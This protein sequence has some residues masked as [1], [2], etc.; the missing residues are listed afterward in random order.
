M[1][2]SNSSSNH[3]H[4][5]F[6][7]V[8]GNHHSTSTYQLPSTTSNTTSN[9]IKSMS[10][11]A[12]LG[13][14]NL[15]EKSS[16]SSKDF[17]NHHHSSGHGASVQVSSNWAHTLA[18]PLPDPTQRHHHRSNHKQLPPSHPT[19]T[20][21]TT[22]SSSTATRSTSSSISSSNESTSQ[23]QSNTQPN[24]HTHTH[25]TSTSLSSKSLTRNSERQQTIY[26]PAGFDPFNPK[27]SQ[28]LTSL[29]T[30][31]NQ[32][33]T[34]QAANPTGLCDSP[35]SIE[36][37]PTVQ[38]T[39]TALLDILQDGSQHPHE[40]SIFQR[41]PSLSNTSSKSGPTSSSRN[42]SA[43]LR[44]QSNSTPIIGLNLGLDP[45]NSFVSHPPRAST[46]T[47]SSSSVGSSPLLNNHISPFSHLT[48]HSHLFNH[49]TLI[50]N[51]NL[52][53]HERN[54]TN[55]SNRASGLPF[56]HSD[57]SNSRFTRRASSVNTPSFS[58]VQDDLDDDLPRSRRPSAPNLTSPLP[59]DLTF[60]LNP[61][62]THSR[63]FTE[64]GASLETY[65]FGTAQL[66][67]DL[68]SG[69]RTL[70]NDSY[71]RSQGLTRPTRFDYDDQRYESAPPLP[72]CRTRRQSTL[73]NDSL[74]EINDLF[75]PFD[76]SAIISH[77]NLY[78]P[79][80]QSGSTGSDREKDAPH[81]VRALSTD[82]SLYA[83]SVSSL[84][85]YS[86][87]HHRCRTGS[88]SSGSTRCPLLD[89]NCPDSRR[90]SDAGSIMPMRPLPTMMQADHS[91]PSQ[92]HN[93]YNYYNPKP[94]GF[95]HPAPLGLIR[96]SPTSMIPSSSILSSNP[97]S[98][99][100]SSSN[101]I[102]LPSTGPNVFLPLRRRF[103]PNQ[104]DQRTSNTKPRVETQLLGELLLA[105]E[106]YVGAFGRTVKVSGSHR[107]GAS[108]SSS[109]AATVVVAVTAATGGSSESNGTNLL[110]SVVDLHRL[111]SPLIELEEESFIPNRCSIDS[112]SS[113]SSSEESEIPMRSKSELK[114][115]RNQ[116]SEV[117]EELE[118][119]TSEVVD[120]VPAFGEK[121]MQGHYGPL[122]VRYP[123]NCSSHSPPPLSSQSNLTL[124][125]RNRTAME[126]FR[127]YEPGGSKDGS[128]GG[129]GWWA[130]RLL[131]DLLEGLVSE[132]V[133]STSPSNLLSSVNHKSRGTGQM[134]RK[135]LSGVEEV[136]EGD[137]AEDLL[138]HTIGSVGLG[139]GETSDRLVDSGHRELLLDEGRKRWLAYQAHKRTTR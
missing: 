113:S 8:K 76:K 85:S 97:S 137:E 101:H 59:T 116:L 32:S 39:R 102:G 136:D 45:L 68:Q 41:R 132:S 17:N 42:S 99:S 18:E 139:M 33:T 66:S 91:Q 92:T 2:F 131:R 128:D 84:D 60:K 61:T 54:L 47:L 83:P 20:T 64:F 127:E 23:N 86:T 89:P 103:L 4:Q 93:M 94:K 90:A 124:T 31:P 7:I 65:R 107:L 121:L 96:S 105:L 100:S 10:R 125:F 112:S 95:R 73:K 28:S 38:K 126:R 55:K 110:D 122:A 98:S 78:T 117:C 16:K 34:S 24:T 35:A 104:L 9:H 74:P 53:D 19:T 120:V 44:R 135:D 43:S 57:S 26:L 111:P 27:L 5:L 69:T 114:I 134:N 37:A 49:P 11:L 71:Y 48:H 82:M 88:Y 3:H 81:F 30:Y 130:E 129:N 22:S 106:E 40:K 75:V 80:S 118:Y 79:P 12:Q 13:R 15:K 67:D 25:S 77:S 115:S 138:L 46:S 123:S 108:S 1:S 50:H 56:A 51:L 62:S 14:R 109:V 36:Q 29:P 52:H 87:S 119:V 63:S 133:V 70:S 21:T 58:Q 72:P 6:M